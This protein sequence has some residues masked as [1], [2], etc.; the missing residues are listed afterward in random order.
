MAIPDFIK[1]LRSKIGTDLLQ[2]PTVGVLA[3]DEGGRLLL[4]QDKPSGLWGPP[5]GII[6]PYELPSD[7]AVRETWEEAGVLVEPTRVLG[8]FA[9]A[10]FAGAYENGDQVA[11]VATVFAARVIRGTPRPDGV[12]TADAR[13]F[14]PAEVAKLPCKPHLEVIQRALSLAHHET[15]FTPATWQPTNS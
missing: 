15:Y 5:G 1:S 7:A 2:I 10:H 8:V 13:L 12:E 14:F 6:D 9:G 3:Y 4:V 11:C